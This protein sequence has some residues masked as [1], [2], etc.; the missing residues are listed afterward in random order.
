MILSTMNSSQ[1][2]ASLFWSKEDLHVQNGSSKTLIFH[3]KI[4]NGWSLS[5]KQDLNRG[6]VWSIQLDPI[7]G[8]EQRGQRPCVII[9]PEEMNHQLQ[10]VIILPLSTKKKNW[11]TRVDI[12]FLNIEGQVLCEQV[13][14]VSKTR[15]LEKLGHLP[16]KDIIQIKLVLKQMLIE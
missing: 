12:N 4:F 9:S 8:S 2:K 1:R 14:T 10:T 7:K 5:L 6:D 3:Q 16:I 13:C 11:P 15:L